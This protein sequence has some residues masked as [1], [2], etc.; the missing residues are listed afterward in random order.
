MIRI[1]SAKIK[2]KHDPLRKSKSW[3][4]TLEDGSEHWV[5]YST[6]TGYT[7]AT[8]EIKIKTFMLKLKKIPY[9]L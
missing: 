4:I 3:L 8:K 2:L 7:P 6:I 5:P 1:E 9:K